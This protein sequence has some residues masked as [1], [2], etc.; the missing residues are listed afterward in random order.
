MIASAVREFL[1]KQGVEF[2][3]LPHKMTFTAQEGA[4]VTHVRGLEWAKTVVCLADGEPILAVLPAHFTLDPEKLREV[5]GASVLR[6]AHEVEL[7]KM[8]PGCEL[9]AMPPFGP[10]YNQRVFCDHS[11]AADEEITFNAGT[12]TDAIRMKWADFV[13]LVKPVIGDFSIRPGRH[14]H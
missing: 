12:H 9:G 5:V 10:L 11:L 6:L 2:T 3:T 4:A 1:E 7:S 8:Y 13:N 14:V